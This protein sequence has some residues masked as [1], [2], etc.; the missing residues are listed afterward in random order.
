[1]DLNKS[2]INETVKIAVILREFNYIFAS[3]SSFYNG[4][5]H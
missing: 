2:S 4:K 5:I 3:T 1:M